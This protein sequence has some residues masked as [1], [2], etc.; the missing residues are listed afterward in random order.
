[1]GALSDERS[2]ESEIADCHWAIGQA[3]DPA[4]AM[5]HWKHLRE[6]V[7]RKAEAENRLFG[8]ESK[9]GDLPRCD[10]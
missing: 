3:T 7:A 8:R 10:P 6:L 9:N 4:E 2:I 5:N 1:M